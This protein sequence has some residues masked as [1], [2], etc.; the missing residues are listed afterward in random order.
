MDHSPRPEKNRD[1][2]LARDL[3]ATLD[4]DGTLHPNALPPDHPDANLYQDLLAYKQARPAEPAPELSDE[5]WNRV[6]EGL[7]PPRARILPFMPMYR[8]AAVAAALVI[9]VGVGWF[10]TRQPAA[11][12]PVLLASAS[13]TSVT[14]TAPDGSTVALR[15]HSELY[16]VSKETHRYRLMGEGFFDVTPSPSRTF[17]VEAHDAEITVLGTRFNVSTWSTTPEVYL[18]TG[19]VR[20]GTPDT[21]TFVELASGQ[22]SRIGTDGTPSAPDAAGSD[23]YLDWIQGEM[24]VEA[25][26][27]HQVLAELTHHFN[28]QVNAPDALLNETL[29][30]R[31][32]LDTPN[33]SLG[34]LADVIGGRL[35]AVDAQTYRLERE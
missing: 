31:I 9:L 3:G 20:F 4:K 24:N 22:H 33:Q 32:M 11:P 18:E 17:T 25:R 6:A 7:T 23:E 8:W 27:L 28:I 19:R 26:P 34:D 10:L 16:Q 30:G 13:D 15:P 5:L 21:D 14:Y 1:L 2:T 35:V 29:S 12:V